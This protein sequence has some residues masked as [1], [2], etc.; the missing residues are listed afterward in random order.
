MLP[1]LLIFSVFLLFR[2]HNAPGGG[3]TGGLIAATAF[4]L[5]SIAYDA[6]SVRQIL[7]IE[8]RALIGF[9]LLA[10]IVS[11]LIGIAPDGTFLR[12]TWLDL[13][14]PMLGEIH[15]GN[16]LLF[17]IGVY[18]VVIGIALTIV[19]TIAEQEEHA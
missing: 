10:A 6:A 18:L 8:P 5:Y 15:L 17:D 13:H 4:A 7:H 16:V 2:G 3:F 14:A 19:L 9:G 11:G 1:L 12:A